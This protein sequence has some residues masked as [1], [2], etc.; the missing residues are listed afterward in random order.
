M[1]E[2]LTLEEILERIPKLP[3]EMILEIIAVAA[4]SMREFTYIKE[5]IVSHNPDIGK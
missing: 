2:E 5:N 1:S 4:K 3:M